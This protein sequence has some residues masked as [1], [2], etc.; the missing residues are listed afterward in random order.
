MPTEPIMTEPHK[1]IDPQIAVAAGIHPPGIHP[2][3]LRLGYW[4]S[5]PDQDDPTAAGPYARALQSANDRVAKAKR[6]EYVSLYV[7]DLDM[8][9]AGVTTKTEYLAVKAARAK[10]LALA[11]ASLPWPGEHVDPT[12]PQAERERVAALLDSA[13]D[14]G[15][16]CGSSWDR[17][18]PARSS[19]GSR[20]RSAGGRIWPSGLSTYVRKY[21]LVIDPKALTAIERELAHYTWMVP[22]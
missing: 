1:H 16:Y 17:L 21:G 8:E 13:P 20:E 2:G 11:Q 5:H 6:G 7:S 14:V 4:R 15:G 22:R 9:R 3:L 10:N 12:M 19:N 18:D